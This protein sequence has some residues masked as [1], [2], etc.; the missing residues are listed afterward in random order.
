MRDGAQVRVEGLDAHAARLAVWRQEN[1]AWQFSIVAATTTTLPAGDALV[2]SAVNRAGVESA[3]V[4][5]TP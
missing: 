5:F 4:T 1:G 2:V 3:R